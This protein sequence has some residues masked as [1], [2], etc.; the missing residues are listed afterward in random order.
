MI[1]A[2]DFDLHF[3]TTRSFMERFLEMQDKQKDK[4]CLNFCYYIIEL[5]LLDCEILQ[6]TPSLI[7]MGVIYLVRKILGHESL[8]DTNLHGQL[9]FKERSVRDCAR[10]IVKIVN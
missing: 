2:L 9:G 8:W 4:K 5:L 6:F 3:P 10:V 1:T 7:A